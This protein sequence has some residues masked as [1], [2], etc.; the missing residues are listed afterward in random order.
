MNPPLPTVVCP[1]CYIRQTYHAPNKGVYYCTSCGKRISD[2]K[3]VTQ[4]FNQGVKK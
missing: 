2:W 4:L 1:H 3:V